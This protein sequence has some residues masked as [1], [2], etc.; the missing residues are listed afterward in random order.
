MGVISG[1]LIQSSPLSAS[2][3]EESLQWQSAHLPLLGSFRWSVVTESREPLNQ[4]S[5]LP[6]WQ[7]LKTWSS[8]K[9][10]RRRAW[11]PCPTT[12]AAY[13]PVLLSTPS[14]PSL[15]GRMP[16]TTRTQSMRCS[17]L[18]ASVP[19]P[20]ADHLK[21]KKNNFEDVGYNIQTTS[22]IH[23]TTYRIWCMM[24]IIVYIYD[25]M[26]VYIPAYGL[27]WYLSNI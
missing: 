9:S 24:Y 3:A 18:V 13:P 14:F 1:F 15:P 2:D 5:N 17:T 11:K 25:Y 12:C 22:K 27:Q 7:R 21:K 23:W 8:Q 4:T 10:R 16:R 26:C 19:R 20:P 6:T